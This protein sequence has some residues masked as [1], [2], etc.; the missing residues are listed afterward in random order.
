MANFYIICKDCETKLRKKLGRRKQRMTKELY[1]EGVLFETSHSITAN[2]DEIKEALTCPR[3]QGT[4]CEKTF[5]DYNVVG[6]IR[7]N[8]YL[9]RPRL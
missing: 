6:Y 8:G 5:L 9:D 4:N 1:E 2:A 7:G 3:C